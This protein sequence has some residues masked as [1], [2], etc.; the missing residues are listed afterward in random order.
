M[1]SRSDI[2]AEARRWI[3][4]PYRHQGSTIGAGADCLGLVRGV[5]RRLLGQEP[6]PIP[7]YTEDWS[8]PNRDEALLAAAFRCLVPKDINS[9]DIGDVLVF[10]MRRNSI[11]KHLG[12]AAD[13]IAGPTFIHAYSGHGVVETHLSRPW[14]R[15][16]AGR[17]EFPLGVK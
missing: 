2:V 4:T 5:W 1:I 11:A 3:D 10:R 14:T 12:I 9:A 16:I 13:C 6:E 17:F 8:E 15:R 7:A